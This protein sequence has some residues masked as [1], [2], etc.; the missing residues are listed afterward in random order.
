MKNDE[1]ATKVIIYEIHI[2][3]NRQDVIFLHAIKY[4][5]LNN[6]CKGYQRNLAHGK[7]EFY[8][9]VIEGWLSCDDHHRSSHTG[10]HL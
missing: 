1:N 5:V 10:L 9:V 4:R 7:S 2:R 3:Q 6:D 8:K